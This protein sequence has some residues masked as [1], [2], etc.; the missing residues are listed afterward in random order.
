MIAN[1]ET[2]NNHRLAQFCQE[3]LQRAFLTANQPMKRKPFENTRHRSRRYSL[4]M[5]ANIP[6]LHVKGAEFSR[7]K[8]F[9]NMQ[10]LSLKE[11][12]AFIGAAVFFYW[13]RNLFKFCGSTA[14]VIKGRYKLQ[15][16][17]VFC[18]HNGKQTV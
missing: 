11:V 17:I 9:Q 1:M 16:P 15:I 18:L 4:Q 8:D 3:I 2:S 10:V 13:L 5:R 14:M 12:Q 7:A 6:V